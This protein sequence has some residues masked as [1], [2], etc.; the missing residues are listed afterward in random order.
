MWGIIVALLAVTSAAAAQETPDERYA[1]GQVWEYRA[2]AEDEGS[3]LKIQA[4]E[5][6]PDMAAVGPI[7]HVSVIGIHFSN[8]GMATE[9]QHMP[10]SRQTLDASVI[11]LSERNAVFPDPASGI[12]QWR[13]AQG[14]VYTIPLA[15]IIALTDQMLSNQMPPQH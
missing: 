15:E 6:L 1:A 10:V 5:T 9:I 4:I 3:L 7:Y 8:P 14:G 13:Q 12:Q 2:R 11:Q